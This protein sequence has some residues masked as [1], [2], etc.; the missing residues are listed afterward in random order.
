MNEVSTFI[1]NPSDIMGWKKKYLNSLGL[2]LKDK[3]VERF[4]V[5]TSLGYIKISLGNQHSTLD[6][7]DAMIAHV[8]GHL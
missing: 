7:L 2:A 8:D 6:R 1:M 4:N 5:F 3:K